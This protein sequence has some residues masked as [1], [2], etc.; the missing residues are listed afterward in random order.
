MLRNAPV[1]SSSDIFAS[2]S[3]TVVEW[4]P[5]DITTALWLDAADSDTIMLNGSN[6]SQWNDKSTNDK[7]ATQ[8]G[9]TAQPAYTSGGLNGLNIIEFDGSNDKL[10][11]T[12]TFNIN[13][14]S[15]F[16]VARARSGTE[17]RFMGMRPT[18]NGRWYLR[19]N[20]IMKGSASFSPSDDTN[21]R[22]MYLSGSSTQAISSINAAAPTAVADTYSATVPNT[23]I[24]ASTEA[25]G[26][27]T[28]D[29]YGNVAISEVI[30]LAGTPS[31]EDRQKIEGY[32]AW[33]W[34]LEANLP[35]GHPY[36]DGPPTV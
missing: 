33:K 12:H 35:S 25:A 14:Q 23:R 16:M 10:T 8:G 18:T 28:P 7:H 15:V 31:D 21:W 11:S 26:G 3:E 19:S 29:V 4:T 17:Q 24:G 36:E 34:G 5:A 13:N 32:L 27:S 2:S 9:S 6:V 20:L 1:D 22:I 30:M